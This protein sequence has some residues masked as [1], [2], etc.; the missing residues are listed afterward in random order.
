[1]ILMGYNEVMKNL[2][3]RTDCHPQAIDCYA[4]ETNGNSRDHLSLTQTWT[5][6]SAAINS[7]YTA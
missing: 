2:T 5:K 1:M 6:S 3:A 7:S 4:R